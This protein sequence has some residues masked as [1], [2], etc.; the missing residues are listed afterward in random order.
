M[1]NQLIKPG[2]LIFT[3]DDTD[4]TRYPLRNGLQRRRMDTT[5]S[6]DRQ[7]LIIKS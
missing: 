1:T 7:R 2:Y 3:P 6:P 5:I 4:L